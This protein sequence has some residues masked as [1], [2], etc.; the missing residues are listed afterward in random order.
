M[1]RVGEWQL[2]EPGT[3]PEYTTEQWYAG[4]DNAAH[5][6]DA[7]HRPRM[8]RSSLMVAHAA[9]SYGLSTVVDLGAG[10]GGLLSLLGPRLKAWGY[11]L[12]PAAV[13]AA[14]ARG[15]DVRQGNVLTDP[16]EWADIAVATEMLEHLVD[17]HALV[18]TIRE[19]CR[20]VVA[21]SPHSE[22]PGAAYE[23]HTF[24]WDFGGYAAMFRA[25]GWRIVR[26][27]PVGPFQVLMAVAS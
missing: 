6:E 9:A 7:H 15:V 8:L 20:A 22:R 11:D 1:V 16:V 18:A 10:D 14:R 19:H 4:R 3:I 17:P 27:E 12:A 25:A 2:F 23:F 21:S 5:L 24:A 26:H 13:A